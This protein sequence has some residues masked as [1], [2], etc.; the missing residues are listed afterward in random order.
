MLVF[1]TDID[2]KA[3][4]T[5]RT[6]LYPASIAADI[7]PERLARYF[8]PEPGDGAFRIHK[9]I[10][11]MLVFSEQNVIKD[12]PFSR[13]DLISCRNLMIYLSGDLQ[14]KII[15][16]FHYAL[17]PGGFL[18]LGTSETVGEFDD[19][20][21]A[22]D[23]KAKLYQ[24]REDI[25]G[26]RRAGLGRFLPPMTAPHMDAQ[27]TDA[28]TASPPKIPL[29]ELTETALLEE[30]FQAG[31][32][33][34][35]RGDILYLHGRTGAYLEPTPGENGPNN[36]LKMAREG[37]RRDL[38]TALHKAV[39]SGETVRCPGLRVKTNGDV[40]T[41][42]LVVRPVATTP[43][44]PAE[45]LLY[46][47]IMEPAP[48]SMSDG[49]SALPDE[50]DGKPSPET[51]QGYADIGA[52]ITTLRHELKA[53]EEYLQ[54]TN[55]ELQTA[56]EEM[57]SINEELQST[58]EELETSKEELQSVNEELSTV[59]AELQTKV[60]DLSRANNDMNNL[61]AGTGI[62]TVFVDHQLHIL[63]FTPAATKII[64]LIHSDIGRPVSHI[65]SN[66]PG[67]NTLT[68]DT[69]AVLDT[70][71]PKEADV[72]TSEGRWYSMCIQPYRTM[73]NVI[74]GAVLTFM[75]VTAA[76]ELHE[77]LLVNEERLRV[78]LNAS[79]ISVSNQDTDLRYTWIRNPNSGFSAEQTIGK[80]D[81]ELWPEPEAA[82]LTAIKQQALETGIGVRKTIQ[83][84]HAGNPIAYDLTVEPLHD[85]AGAVI[86][87]TCAS[88]RVTGPPHQE[89]R[90]SGA[91]G[92]MQS[93]NNGS[94]LC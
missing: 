29:R 72:R 37:L 60:T 52:Q 5:A 8:S 74:E 81:A 14:K 32:L 2:G 61:L 17:K 63:R 48:A 40:T 12:P 93:E 18:F 53:K 75:D 11:D 91:N 77:A 34:N 62:A 31:A 7:A 36:I 27:I 39:G 47:V 69:Q 59:N 21:T 6:G 94:S 50:T 71:V 38:V 46:L 73:E 83:A 68:E 90:D 25:F 79:C 57:Q 24:R 41:V 35:A 4:A 70:L 66:L 89:R 65:V 26:A 54:T 33:V 87:I 19:L 9:A 3:I 92:T 16:L 67:Y 30:V 64:N 43:D 1:A 13:L 78:A 23:R 44:A 42:N 85:A 22:L 10:R 51:A 88:L 76:R 15:S 86:G 45:P 49:K 55:E 20:F 58:N 56:N 80:T 82:E 28:K 84:T